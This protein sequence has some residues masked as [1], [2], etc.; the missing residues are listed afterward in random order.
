MIFADRNCG[1]IVAG[2][3]GKQG[4]FHIALMNQYAREVGGKGVVAGS[5]LERRARRSPVSRSTTVSA[6]PSGSTT[7]RRVSSLSPLLPQRIPSWNRQARG[8]PWLLL[9]P[10]TSRCTIR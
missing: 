10:S 2:A 5:P 4:A 3:T 6:T 8:C 7:Q 9:S 1:V